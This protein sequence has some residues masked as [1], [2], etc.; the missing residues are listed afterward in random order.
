MKA[1]LALDEHW[2]FWTDYVSKRVWANLNEG[3]NGSPLNC[4][5]PVCVEARRQV[6]EERE[7]LRR[8]EGGLR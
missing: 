1:Q 3:H 2:R 4:Q 8:H 5:H 7:R 6:D